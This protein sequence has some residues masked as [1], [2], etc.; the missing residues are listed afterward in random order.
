M[1][2]YGRDRKRATVSTKVNSG[3]YLIVLHK[4]YPF[5]LDS[6]IP[7]EK[8][9]VTVKLW[10]PKTP[11][12]DSEE[13]IQRAYNHLYWAVRDHLSGKSNKADSKDQSAS[14]VE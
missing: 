2:F 8:S 1:E 13:R 5:A 11:S 7:E 9:A 12:T 4:L 6:E 14:T 3:D 10:M